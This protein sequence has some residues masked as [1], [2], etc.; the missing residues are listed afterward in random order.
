VVDQNHGLGTLAA[1]IVADRRSLPIDLMHAR[2]LGVERSLA[3][4]EACDKCTAG[5]LAED[6]AIRPPLLLER[7]L[8][9]V[10]QT[11]AH[12]AEEAVAGIDDLVLG[13]G[14]AVGRRR[15]RRRAAVV[16]PGSAIGLPVAGRA[17]VRAARRRVRTIVAPVVV[18][19]AVDA[20]GPVGRLRI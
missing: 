3:V 5:I 1:E 4:A 14:V 15:S 12:R 17:I 19:L 7:V 2:V 13:V 20:A 10:R 16:V 11:F 18:V 6:V 8:D 9:D